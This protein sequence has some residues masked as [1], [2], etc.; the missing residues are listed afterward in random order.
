MGHACVMRALIV[1]SN[2]ALGE[3]WKKHL[4]R[5]DIETFLVGGQSDAATHIHRLD[6]NVLVIDIVLEEGSALA[7][8]DLASYRQP[9]AKVVF[10]TNTSFFSD[11]SIF[12]LCPNACAFLQ[13]DSPPEDIAATAYHYGSAER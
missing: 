5:H 3:L 13:A 12:R 11:G 9:E 10:V 1:E 7:V 6:F 4:E 2:T 8:A